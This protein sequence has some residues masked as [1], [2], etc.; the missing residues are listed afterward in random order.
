MRDWKQNKKQSLVREGGM[1]RKDLNWKKVE[2]CWKKN[3]NFNKREEKRT[4]E[5]EL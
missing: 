1:K 4:R 2:K 5:N 3:K